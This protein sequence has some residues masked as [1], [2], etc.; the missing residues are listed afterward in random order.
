M[1]VGARVGI[2]GVDAEALRN[3]RLVGYVL[4]VAIVMMITFE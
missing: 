2:L 3:Q 1:Q 4:T